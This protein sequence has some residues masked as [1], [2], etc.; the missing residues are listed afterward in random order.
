MQAIA[1]HLDRHHGTGPTLGNL[2]TQVVGLR[3]VAATGD[4][5]D[6]SPETDADVFRAA[7][8]S[9]GELGVIT[10]L[11]M[12]LLPLYRLHEVRTGSRSTPAWPRSTSGSR[13]T[14]ISSS[15]VS[16]G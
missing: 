1:A 16:H 14:G 10:S 15:L 4:V 13:R 2:S 5:I 12:R 7:Q 8:V 6:C 9:L 11:R 3:M